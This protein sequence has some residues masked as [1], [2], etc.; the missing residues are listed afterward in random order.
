MISEADRG[1]TKGLVSHWTIADVLGLT[2]VH[3]NRTLQSLRT[4]R[5]IEQSGHVVTIRDWPALQQEAG[6]RAGY[7]RLDDQ[8][9]PDGRSSLRPALLPQPLG[10]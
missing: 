8:N 3:V 9:R 5:V 4:D 2:S 1:P 7:L 10:L 6:F